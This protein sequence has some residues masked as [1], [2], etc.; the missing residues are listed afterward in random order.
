MVEVGKTGALFGR[1]TRVVSQHCTACLMNPISLLLGIGIGIEIGIGMG[2]FMPP[3][4]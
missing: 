4:G 1:E 3:V 2:W